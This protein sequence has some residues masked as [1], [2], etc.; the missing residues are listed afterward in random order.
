MPG[1]LKATLAGILLTAGIGTGIAGYNAF[2]KPPPKYEATI[3][4][5]VEAATEAALE[6]VQ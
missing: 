3:G 4:V 5:D 1:G 6:V 2:L